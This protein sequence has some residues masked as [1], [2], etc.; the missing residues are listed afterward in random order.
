MIVKLLFFVCALML[1]LHPVSGFAD[2]TSFN[3]APVS[4]K[5]MGGGLPVG[6]VIVWP[7]SSQ[8]ADAENWLECNGQAISM[9]QYP[10]LYAIVG[11]KLPDYRGMF[12][13]GA[14]SQ[15]ID[16]VAYSS[17]G[18]SAVQKYSL[19]ENMNGGSFVGVT[20]YVHYRDSA[21][22]ATYGD[23]RG[24]HTG[25]FSIYNLEREV[26]HAATGGTSGNNSIY[27]FGQIN[28][29]FA[30]AGG[31]SANEIRPVNMAVRYLIR[32]KP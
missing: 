6:A 11:A 12:L 32:A 18:L 13:R 21:P 31:V 30:G 14:G 17:G 1:T 3:P 28:V 26:G 29:D 9:Q 2:S 25:A 7:V 24:Y 4:I 23:F 5:A 27:Y 8:P 22:V 15:T 19:T 10:D 20:K 16:G